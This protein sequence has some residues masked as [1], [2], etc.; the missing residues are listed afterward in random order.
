[1]PKV[2]DHDE[3]R[4]EL[5]S[6]CFDL[7]ADHGYASLTTRQIAKALGVSTGTLYYY[8][9]SKEDL[10]MQLIEELT[11][12]DLLRATAQIQG[13]ST[14]RERILA[15][16]DFL[17]ANEDYFIKQTL[18]MMDFYQQAG[19]GQSRVNEAV[20]RVSVRSRDEIMIALQINDPV[21]ATHVL[22]LCDGLIS[23]R[24]VD[25]AMVSY[26]QQAELLADLLTAYLEKFP[27]G[28]R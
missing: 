8:F 13:L 7:F 11:T 3:Y 9:P 1:M 4:K 17:E 12:Q 28:K 15:L 27:G 5:L 22:C 23:E 24:M 2:V 21:V 6:Q 26:R 20:Q 25:P 16:G 14:L 18:L 10:F 19:I